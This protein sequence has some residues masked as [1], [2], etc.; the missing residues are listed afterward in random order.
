MRLLDGD[1][2]HLAGF[3]LRGD[4]GREFHYLERL[5]VH[6]HD[7]VVACLNPDFAPA[8]GDAL[9]LCR[10]EFTAAEL[11][12]ECLVFSA[13][14]IG[15][16]DEHAVM[17]ALDLFKRVADGAEEVRVGVQ[18]FAF[19]RKFDHRLRLVDGGDDALFGRIHRSFLEEAHDRF[20]AVSRGDG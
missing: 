15:R 16:L 18:D 19:R 8:L 10:V 12:P 4:V 20:L 3:H 9:V 5:A 17:L 2:Q 1:L 14:A 11:V 6:I 13:G 7:R